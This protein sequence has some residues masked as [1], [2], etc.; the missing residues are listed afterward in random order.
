[1]DGDSNRIEM[2]RIEDVKCVSAQLESHT[3]RDVNQ[4]LES[5]VEVTIAR[6]TKAVN[7]WSTTRV[8]VKTVGGLERVQVEERFRWVNIAQRLCIWILTGQQSG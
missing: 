1:L 8:E 6:L 2:V 4:L 7:P 3:L 5:E